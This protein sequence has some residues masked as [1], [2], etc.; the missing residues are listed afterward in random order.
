MNMSNRFNVVNI[1]VISLYS[2]FLSYLFW[3]ICNNGTCY[4]I[5]A[6]P[7]NGEDPYSLLILLPIF[8]I[9]FFYSSFSLIKYLQGYGFMDKFGSKKSSF[10]KNPTKDERDRLLYTSL[11]GFIIGLGLTIEIIWS[12]SKIL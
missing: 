4:S 12:I 2:L 1:F 9:P 7:N 6:N 5:M 8:L 11:P 10:I 3:P